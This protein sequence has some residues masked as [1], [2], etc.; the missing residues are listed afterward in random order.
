[1][2]RR[3]NWFAAR[4]RGQAWQEARPRGRRDAFPRAR[5]AALR[6]PR[7]GT[8]R[9]SAAPRCHEF[10]ET[11]NIGQANDAAAKSGLFG[12]TKTLALETARNGI[13]VNCFAPGFIATDMVTAVPE[14]A[15]AKVVAEIPVGRRG[16]PEEIARVVEFLVDPD[17][18]SITGSI[19][20]VNGGL[21]M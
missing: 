14:E 8:R 1:M 21:N 17:A 19:V 20:S 15:L 6:V 3:G 4:L 12:L 13:T 16:E 2:A 11:G 5:D 10:G 9:S 18:G 7:R